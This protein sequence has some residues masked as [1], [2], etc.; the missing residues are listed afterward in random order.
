MIQGN[1]YTLIQGDADLERQ[2]IKISSKCDAII[3]CRA[4]PSQK[5][6]VVQLVKNNLH[7]ETDTVLA[8]GDGSNDVAMIHAAHIGVGLTGLE[9]AEAASSADYAI[10]EFQRIR[11]LIFYHGFG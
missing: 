3:I 10:D 2:F 4:S 1:T 5:A 7:S 6:S 11:R 8:I 9:G